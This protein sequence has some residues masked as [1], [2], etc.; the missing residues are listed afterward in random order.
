M[1]RHVKVFLESRGVTGHEPLKC[2]WC[3]RERM[4]DV[5]HIVPKGMGGNKNLDMPGNL[6]GLCRGCHEK[7][8]AGKIGR[9]KL[10]ARTALILFCI[11][12]KETG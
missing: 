2:E 5:H 10:L 11:N 4:A 12:N 6:A 8:H 9:A 3:F 7:A 1:K